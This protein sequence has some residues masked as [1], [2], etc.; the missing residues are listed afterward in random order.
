MPSTRIIAPLGLD[1]MWMVSL[2]FATIG[3]AGTGSSA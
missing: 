2:P 1:S 3:D